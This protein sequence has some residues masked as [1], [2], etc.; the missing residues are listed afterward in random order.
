MYRFPC[1][2]INFLELNKFSPSY[3]LENRMVSYCILCDLNYSILLY[4]LSP[5]ISFFVTAIIPLCYSNVRIL[6]NIVHI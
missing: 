5:K 1:V 6:S 3:K 2:R 4:Y